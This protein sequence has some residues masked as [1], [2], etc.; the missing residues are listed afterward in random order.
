M[1]AYILDGEKI[2]R[3]LKDKLNS[4]IEYLKKRSITPYLTAVQVGENQASRVYTRQQKAACEKKGIK[5]DLLEI[6]DEISQD[7]LI[8]EIEKLNTDKSVTGIILQMPLPQGIDARA[9]QVKISPD[10]DVEGIHP[11]NMGML[12]YGKS[13]ASPP[14]ASAAMELL[15][16]SGIVLKG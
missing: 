12:L 1:A 13:A 15:K 9:V 2:A 7:E 14:T 8:R 11:L 10:K 16:Y 6:A 4:E 3:E 5:Y